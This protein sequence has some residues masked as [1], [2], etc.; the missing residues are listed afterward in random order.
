MHV[1]SHCLKTVIRSGNKIQSVCPEV[2][3]APEKE[4]MKKCLVNAS[5]TLRK[6]LRITASK[7]TFV[8]TRE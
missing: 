1:A 4:F 8:N 5:S 7:E 2:E 3:T 6:E